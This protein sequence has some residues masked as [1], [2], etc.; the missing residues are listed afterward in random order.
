MYRIDLKKINQIAI[1][2]RVPRKEMKRGTAIRSTCIVLDTLLPDNKLQNLN[3]SFYG[4][5][6]METSP[7]R[8][9]FGFYIGSLRFSC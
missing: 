9:I 3:I 5:S 7:S 2:C 6:T 8:F 4:A 1:N